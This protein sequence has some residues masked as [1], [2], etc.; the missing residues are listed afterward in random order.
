MAWRNNIQTQQTKGESLVIEKIRTFFGKVRGQHENKRTVVVESVAWYCAK[1][2]Q[3]WLD[4]DEAYFHTCKGKQNG[5][6]N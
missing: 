1:C 2:K 4:R 6:R 3:V 5:N